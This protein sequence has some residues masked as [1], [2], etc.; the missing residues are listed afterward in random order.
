M[1]TTDPNSK[2]IPPDLKNFYRNRKLQP[3]SEIQLNSGNCASFPTPANEIVHPSLSS[4]AGEYSMG[5]DDR[6]LQNPDCE[7]FFSPNSEIGEFSD[8]NSFVPANSSPVPL[9]LHSTNIIDYTM[10]H[11]DPAML[12]PDTNFC[13]VNRKLEFR[14]QSDADGI[15]GDREPLH[16]DSIIRLSTLTREF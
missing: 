8:H 11:I 6:N 9:P 7:M 15:A 4:G 1:S 14:P 12:E 3:N 5:T 10:N 2:A 16:T 13:S